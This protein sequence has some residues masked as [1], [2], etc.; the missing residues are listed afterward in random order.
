M[1]REV[2]R[3]PRPMPAGSTLTSLWISTYDWKLGVFTRSMRNINRFGIL[4]IIFNAVLFQ[5]AVA[6]EINARTEVTAA[7]AALG[8]K[9]LRNEC[10]RVRIESSCIRGGKEGPTERTCVKEETVCEVIRGKLT[11]TNVN[12]VRADV[13]L[14]KLTTA[15]LPDRFISKTLTARNC[16]STQRAADETINLQ[17]LSSNSITLPATLTETAQDTIKADFKI[18]ALSLGGQRQVTT[19]LQLQ[20]QRQEKQ[21]QTV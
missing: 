19:N 20:K 9:N 3:R 7:L 21:D 2:R 16:T 8:D 6:R 15:A 1:D 14:G 13:R 4:A 17:A 10:R 18:D 5:Q 12:I 11:P